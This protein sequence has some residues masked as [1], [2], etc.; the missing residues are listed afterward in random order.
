MNTFSQKVI[1]YDLQG[2]QNSSKNRGVGQV[3]S[4]IAIHL[5]DKKSKIKFIYSDLFDFNLKKNS[6]LSKYE[7]IKFT[8]NK[9]ISAKKNQAL[10]EK[11]INSIDGDIYFATSYLDCLKD[12]TISIDPAKIKKKKIIL[13][14]DAIPMHDQQLYLQDLIFK[15]NYLKKFNS[16]KFFDHI[17]T[18]S[19]FVKEDLKNL[20]KIE[21]YKIT[22]IKGAVSKNYICKKIFYKKKNFIFFHGPIDF[23]KNIVG[24]IDGFLKSKASSQSKLYLAGISEKN[25]EKNLKKNFEKN[26]S[27]NEKVFFLGYISS[28][29]VIKYLRE[30][31]LYVFPSLDEGFGLPLLEAMSS[32]APC[33]SSNRSSLPEILSIKK[34]LFDPVKTQEITDKIDEYFFSKKKLTKLNMKCFY[35][36]KNFSWNKSIKLLLKVINKI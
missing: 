10:Y 22:D 27:F 30:C 20:L 8:Y 15:K 19:N 29:N 11:K 3:T 34:Y 33:I 25:F 36:S 1:I 28:K 6:K 2:M 24:L 17:F 12:G 31:K 18:L 5:I 35:L 23:R 9:K 16:L 32:G 21:S 26:S 14:H 13:F 7:F 4:N